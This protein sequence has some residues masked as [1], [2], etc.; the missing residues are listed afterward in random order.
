MALDQ[1]MANMVT[2]IYDAGMTG[3]NHTAGRPH[4]NLLN[5]TLFLVCVKKIIC[6]F[7]SHTPMLV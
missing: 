3:K 4:V 2:I 6:C 5:S 1:I 7:Y